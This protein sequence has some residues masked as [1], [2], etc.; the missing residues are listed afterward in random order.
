M[1]ISVGHLLSLIY[2]A[3]ITST[4]VN[5][6]P[7]RRRSTLCSRPRLSGIKGSL[8][9]HDDQNDQDDKDDQDD[10]DDQEVQDD[11]DDQDDQDYQDDQDDQDDQDGASPKSHK[12][13]IPY[14]GFCASIW[15]NVRHHCHHHH[16]I[17]KS[18]SI[19]T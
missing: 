17:Q 6:H 19:N 13:E 7:P 16:H 1:Q 14:M 3:M 18:K 10:Q 4:L 9:D 2:N 11:Q 8:D 15:D 12:H 5:V